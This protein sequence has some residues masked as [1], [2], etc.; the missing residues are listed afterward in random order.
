MRETCPH[1]GSPELGRSSSKI[2]GVS[3]G[4]VAYGCGASVDWDEAG[5]RHSHICAV[6]ERKTDTLVPQDATLGG[7]PKWR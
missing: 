6:Q 7:F 1:C 3:R 5:E 4:S 2:G